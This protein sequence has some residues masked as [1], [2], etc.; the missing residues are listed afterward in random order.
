MNDKRIDKAIVDYE[1]ME[2]I[3]FCGVG[4]VIETL[5]SNE[6]EWLKEGQRVGLSVEDIKKSIKSLPLKLFKHFTSEQ[7]LLDNQLN[8]D[9]NDD[10]IIIATAI[11]EAYKRTVNE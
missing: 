4:N 1:M 2:K 9:L 8:E 6:K 11:H 7:L 5:K 3:I 10:W